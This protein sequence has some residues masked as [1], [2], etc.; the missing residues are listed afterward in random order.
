M[1]KKSKKKK[2]KKPQD[3][4][5]KIFQEA[6]LEPEKPFDFGGLPDINFK[7]NLGC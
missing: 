7:K 4:T 6:N 3:S 2:I 1:K 5:K